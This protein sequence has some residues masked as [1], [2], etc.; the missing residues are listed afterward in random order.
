MIW[1]Q[2]N[3]CIVDTLGP[4]KARAG[5]LIIKVSLIPK[6]VDYAGVLIFK[7]PDKQVLLYT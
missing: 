7:C 1:L 4:T 3:L 6:C 5:V 2:L